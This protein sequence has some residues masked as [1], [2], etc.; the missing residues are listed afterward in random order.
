[1]AATARR[2]PVECGDIDMRI[3][4]DGTWFYHGSPIG[5][6]PLVQLFAKVLRRED[7]GHYYLVTPAERARIT[8]EDAPFVAVEVDVAGEGRNQALTFR[9]SLDDTVTA[10]AAHPIRVALDP[11]TGEPSPYVVVRP[12]LEARINRTVF[13]QLVEMGVEEPV[14]GTPYYGVWSCNTFFPI[15]PAERPV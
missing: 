3:A 5:R 9:T 7:D 12:G 4:R 11:A 15:G 10:D 1:M 14:Q 13:Y 2:L 6:K 8:V